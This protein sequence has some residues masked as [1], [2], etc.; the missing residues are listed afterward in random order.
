MVS[1]S[2]KKTTV[3]GSRHQTVEWLVAFLT[4]EPC[5]FSGVFL[6][7][8]R[9]HSLSELIMLVML[10]DFPQVVFL[11]PFWVSSPTM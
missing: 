9:P 5:T 7:E 2:G 1:A 11:L 8:L 3:L 6:A 10:S 4:A